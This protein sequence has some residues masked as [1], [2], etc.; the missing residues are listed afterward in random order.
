MGEEGSAFLVLGPGRDWPPG[1]APGRDW[2]L[3]SSA[4]GRDR[5]RRSP[6]GSMGRLTGSRRWRASRRHRPRRDCFRALVGRPPPRS[7]ARSARASRSPT[8]MG[9]WPA[10]CSR[11]TPVGARSLPGSACSRRWPWPRSCWSPGWR[12]GG[13]GGR[14][15]RVTRAGVVAS[16]TWGGPEHQIGRGKTRSPGRPGGTR[17][18]GCPGGTRSLGSLR[19]NMI[20]GRPRRQ[21][22]VGRP[23][24][25]RVVSGRPR[26]RR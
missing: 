5:R 11:S 3:G 2:C 12:I 20:T 8:S 22:G 13:D 4:P 9:D 24:R 15:A 17:S 16:R 19:G 14:V 23:R 1:S 10:R 6:R 18:L 21:R 26:G 7:W 25:E